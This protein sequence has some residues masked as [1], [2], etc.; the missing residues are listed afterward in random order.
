[1][2]NREVQALTVRLPVQL[3]AEISREAEAMER[4]I[5]NQIIYWIKKGMEVDRELVL[6]AS[7]ADES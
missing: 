3:Y 6:Q 2:G 4:S 5:T 1:M 7:K